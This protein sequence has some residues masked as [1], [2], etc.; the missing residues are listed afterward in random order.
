MDKCPLV[1]IIMPVYNNER[2]IS[3]SIESVT[4]QTYKNWEL[5]IVDDKSTDKSYSIC[6][7]YS[8]N[9]K[10]ITLLQALINSGPAIARNLAIDHSKGTYIAFLD[11]DD[12]WQKEKLE[13]QITYMQNHNYLLTYTYYQKFSN[14][15]KLQ[16]NNR[17]VKAP[18]KTSY[19]KLLKSNVIG[20]LTAVY[21]AQAIGKI[22]MQNHSNE[23]YIY[24][25]K[26]L[27]KI[28]FAYCLNE[29]LAFYRIHKTSLSA[30]KFKAAKNQWKVY[31]NIEKISFIKSIYY[32]SHYALKGF[33]KYLK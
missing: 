8:K 13:R 15:R 27:K 23:D 11:S 28:N 32:F 6:Q 26:I 4:Q 31:R 10:R 12:I 30:N 29:N 7:Q 16:E 33:I 17:I 3:E 9:D 22:S 18:Q 25:L 1:S 20:N 19:S 5:I 2:F 24:W 14:A 21:N